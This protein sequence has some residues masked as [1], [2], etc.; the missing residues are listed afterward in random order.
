MDILLYLYNLVPSLNP[1]RGCCRA[2][3]PDLGD[4]V[5]VQ[6]GVKDYAEVVLVHLALG[7]GDVEEGGLED[8]RILNITDHSVGQ[9]G[10]ALARV[11]AERKKMQ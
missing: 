2:P 8:Q 1:C 4:H 9:V 3:K 10:Q 6:P 11:S 7:G 5:L